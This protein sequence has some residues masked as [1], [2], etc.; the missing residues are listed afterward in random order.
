MLRVHARTIRLKEVLSK[1]NA[2]GLTPHQ[3]YVCAIKLLAAFPK[4]IPKP[5]RSVALYIAVDQM[6][7]PQ[8]LQHTGMVSGQFFLR[9]LLLLGQRHGPQSLVSFIIVKTS[10]CAWLQYSV[11]RDDLHQIQ[12]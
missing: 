4:I 5:Y 9:V 8:P 7:S 12:N 3:P 11:L 10:H 1:A 2:S 6:C